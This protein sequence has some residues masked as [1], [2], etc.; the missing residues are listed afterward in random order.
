MLRAL[1]SVCRSVS[2]RSLGLLCWC[3]L[4]FQVPAL[5]AQAWTAP[6]AVEL[7]ADAPRMRI[8]GH[9]DEASWR[10]APVYDQ[11]IQHRPVTA[12][13]PAGLRTTVRIVSDG[14][15]LIFGFRA[16]DPQPELMRGALTR[17][18]RVMRDQ[19]FV[20][21][22]LDPTGRRRVAQF[23]R[24]GLGGSVGDGVHRADDDEEDF[25]PDFPVEAAVQRLS[26]GYSV[27]L[28]WPL[29][30]LRYSYEG[31]QPWRVMVGRSVPHAE[32]ALLLSAPLTHDALNFIAEMQVLEGMDLVAERVRDQSFAS[33]R[34]E[35][36]LRR[37]HSQ[38]EGSDTQ[39]TRGSL[40]AEVKW[41]PRADWV[42]DLLLNPDFA[43][44]ELDAPP[45]TGASRLAQELPEKRSYFLE[46]ADVLGLPLPAF[47]SRSVADPRWGLR[48]TWRGAQADATAL[49]LEDRAGGLPVRG[50]PYATL[51]GTTSRPSQVSLARGRWLAEPAGLGLVASSRDWGAGL[52][53]QVL[54]LD[55][56]WRGSSAGQ[57]HQLRWLWMGSN[58][59]AALGEEGQL[60]PDRTR[61]GQMA[62]LEWRQRSAQWHNL[63]T[64]EVIS[65]DF[66]N[67]NGFVARAGAAQV[68]WEINRRLDAES[69]RTRG[70]RMHEMDLHLGLQETRAVRDLRR[71]Q[72]A[73]EVIERHVQ[74]G[75]WVAAPYRTDA[76]LNYGFD[77]QR[78]RTG[79]ALHAV[80][81]WHLGFMT[82]PWPWLAAL[83]GELALGR[84]LDADADR[85]GRG[86]NV[87]IEAR[88][89]WPLPGHMSLE[90][91]HRWA[92]AWVAAPDGGPGFLDASWRWLALL[93]VNPRQSLRLTLQ[94]QH[95]GRAADAVVGLAGVRQQR[96]HLS[97]VWQ[98]RWTSRQS[99]ALGFVREQAPRPWTAQSGR[100]GEWFMKWQWELE[101]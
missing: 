15:S 32:G 5:A 56:H 36:T 81:A 96:D 78:A 42:I 68:R 75:F 18:D 66:A 41:R 43:Q 47:Y 33:F 80:P 14:Q 2:G 22:W 8:D 26:D 69:L 65:P 82:A 40:G 76:W 61:P 86:G 84:Q 12:A 59:T 1:P 83:T 51:L 70:L 3:L 53:N 77:R 57:A 48:A 91:D 4:A 34:A 58:T 37:E 87:W 7:P 67:D 90:S 16:Q 95:S 73:G 27:E 99:W 13:A 30:S 6:R 63:L 101:R 100:D 10:D 94:R 55:G 74:P 25:S 97:L 9:L 85:V 72:P 44:L 17:R 71:G 24:V 60:L 46:S 89:R 45:T 62:W 92:R 23:V 64:A 49:Q 19:D 52:H 31:G 88:T 29:S 28:R 21:V 38:R 98:T 35:W 54:G 11:F 50:S 39:R 79:G 93:H 20:A